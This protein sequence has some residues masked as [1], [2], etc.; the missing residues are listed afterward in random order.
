M[1]L[2]ETH[3][4]LSEDIAEHNDGDSLKL[5]PVAESI[6]YRRRAQSAEKKVEA[7]NEQLAEAKSQVTQLSEQL[8]DIRLEQNLMHKLAAA[9]LP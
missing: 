5:V 3:D 1:S 4:N 7:L 2:V 6:R 9:K 8:N